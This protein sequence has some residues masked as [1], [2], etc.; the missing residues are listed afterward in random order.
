[1][2]CPAVQ[3]GKDINESNMLRQDELLKQIRNAGVI[4][5]FLEY[6]RIDREPNRSYS[7]RVNRKHEHLS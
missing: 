3:Y 7:E 5:A 1:M 6:I 2:E 4:D